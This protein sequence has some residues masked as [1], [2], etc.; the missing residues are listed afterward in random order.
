MIEDGNF[1]R[2]HVVDVT[3]QPPCTISKRSLL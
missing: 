3:S 2:D 1:D